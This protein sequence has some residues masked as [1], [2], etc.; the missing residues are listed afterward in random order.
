MNKVGPHEHDKWYLEYAH[1]WCIAVD[2]GWRTSGTTEIFLLC[3]PDME[4]HQPQEGHG[5]ITKRPHTTK[6]LSSK[7]VLK[8]KLSYT[9]VELYEICHKQTK[10]SRLSTSKIKYVINI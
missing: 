9:P 1:E 5:N 7:T 3:L 8:K 6:C 2:A 4:L 10:K